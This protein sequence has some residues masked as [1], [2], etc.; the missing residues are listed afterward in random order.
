MQET[1]VDV[2]VAVVGVLIG[3]GATFFDGSRTRNKLEEISEKR[4]EP[5]SGSDN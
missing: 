1:F 2:G 4:S 5:A 3:V